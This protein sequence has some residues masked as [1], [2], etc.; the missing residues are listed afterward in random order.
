MAVVTIP[1]FCRKKNS[2]CSISLS[3]C[4]DSIRQ[5][6]VRA[7]RKTGRAKKKRKKE[8]KDKK[9]LSESLF[10]LITPL[11]VLFH[12]HL[13]FLSA[14]P[15]F[16]HRQKKRHRLCTYSYCT[17][18]VLRQSITLQIKGS[19]HDSRARASSKTQKTVKINFMV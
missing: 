1:A 8:W 3:F 4:H 19:N 17:T 13:L 2:R 12:F 10:L 15:I 6:V 9:S 16:A 11:F 18:D 7:N 14:F 5:Y